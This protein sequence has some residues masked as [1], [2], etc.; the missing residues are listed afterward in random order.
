MIC[1][2]YPKMCERSNRKEWDGSGM[3]HVWVEDRCLQVL[4]GKIKV[5][6]HPG[7]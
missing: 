6:K 2:T 5:K 4:V 3:W 7:R 1:T